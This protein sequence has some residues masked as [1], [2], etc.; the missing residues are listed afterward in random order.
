MRCDLTPLPSFWVAILVHLSRN[1]IGQVAHQS[2]ASR[3]FRMQNAVRTY[4]YAAI[5]PDTFFVVKLNSFFF[6]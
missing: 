3:F 2:A 4:F 1:F 5:A 6:R